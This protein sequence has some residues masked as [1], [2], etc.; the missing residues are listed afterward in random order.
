MKAIRNFDDFYKHYEYIEMLEEHFDTKDGI[1]TIHEELELWVDED[2]LG[3]YSDLMEIAKNEPEQYDFELIIDFA[4][5]AVIYEIEIKMAEIEAQLSDA[6]A[7]ELRDESYDA[8]VESLKWY[9]EQLDI[10]NGIIFA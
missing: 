4:Y 7:M 3:K 9:M 8:N 6:E 2:V 1:E 5:Y 10:I